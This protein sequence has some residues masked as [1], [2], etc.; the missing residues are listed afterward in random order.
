VWAYYDLEFTVPDGVQAADW[1]HSEIAIPRDP[2]QSS[3]T[4]SKEPLP[5]TAFMHGNL[6][7]TAGISLAAG[8]LRIF[9]IEPDASLC[10]QVANPPNG[11]TIPAQLLAHGTS[12]DDG[13]VQL[14]L[15]RAPDMP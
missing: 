3:L 13:T 1:T 15:P 11:C 8:E 4:L 9:Q 12:A 10:T 5:A 2:T 6:V 14:A 7:D